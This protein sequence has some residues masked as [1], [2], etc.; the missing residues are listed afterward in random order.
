M[1]AAPIRLQR[2]WLIAA[3]VALMVLLT[4]LAGLAPNTDVGRRWLEQSLEGADLGALGRLHIEGLDGDVWSAPSVRRVTLSDRGGVWMEARSLRFRWR[5][6]SLLD[7]RAQIDVAHIDV[8]RIDHRPQTAPPSTGGGQLPVS[9]HVDRLTARVEMAPKFSGQPGD[10]DLH[11]HLALDRDGTANIGIVAN[12]R[13]ALSDH[14]DA[15]FA[16]SRRK[17]FQ[18]SADL[19]EPAGGALAGMIGLP[20]NQPFRLTARAAGD[21]KA[22]KVSV[23]SRLADS[24]PLILNGAWSEAGGQASGDV[25][26]AASSLLSGYID[27]IGPHLHLVV[28]GRSTGAGFADFQFVGGGANA[29]LVASGAANIGKFAT[30]PKG[31]AMTLKVANAN[32]LSSFP[33][34]GQATFAGIVTGASQR[35]TANGVADL[36]QVSDGGYRLARVSGPLHVTYADREFQIVAEPAGVGGSGEGLLAAL[37]GARPHGR[38]EVNRLADG[39]LLIRSATVEGV[40]LSMTGTGKRG[41]LG[42][43]SFVGTG[44]FTN[45]KLAHAGAHGSVSFGWTA[46]QAGRA[47]W[48]LSVDARGQNFTSG[49][50]E[51]DRLLGR[52][53]RL[54]AKAVWEKSTLS[55][56]ASEIAGANGHLDSVGNIGGDGALALKLAWVA[57]GP[58]A[59]G[60]LEIVGKADG[61]GALTGSIGAPRVDLIADFA[62]VSAPG[63]PLSKAHLILTFQHAADGDDGHFA[64]TAD[65]AYGAASAVSGFRLVSDG[66]DFTDLAVKGGGIEARGALALHAGAP[67]SADLGLTIGPGAMISRGQVHGRLKIAGAAGHA[68]ASASLQG[69]EL[70]LRDNGLAIKAIEITADG[71]VDRLPYRL[72]ANGPSA[73]GPWRIAGNGALAQQNDQTIASFTGGAHWR[74][75]DLRTLAPAEALFTNAGYSL[76]ASLAAGAGRADVAFSNLGP[77]AHLKATVANLDMALL[78]EDYVGKFSGELNLAG[79]GAQLQ[80]DLDARLSGAGGR[81]LRGAPPVNG[82]IKAALAG[83]SMHVRFDLGN[84]SGLAASGEWTLPMDAAAQPFHLAVDGRRH[85]TGRLMV[86]GEVKPIWD[87]A[88][89]GSNSLSGQMNAELNFSGTLADP[90]ASGHLAL[91][92]GRFQDEVSGLDLR[93]VSLHANLI[94][95]V[96]QVSQFSATDPLRGTVTGAGQASLIRDG[97]SNFRA[98][99]SNFRLV[100]TNLARITASGPLS[101]SRAANGK[102][103]ISGALVVDQADISPNP[104]LANGVTPMDVVEI[105]RPDALDD[106]PVTAATNTPREAPV[107]LDVA[108]RAPG[109]VFLKGRGLNLEFALDAHVTG[110][111]VQPDLTGEA[112]VVRG[113]YNFAGQRFLVDDRGIVRL[114]STPQTIRLDLT[115]TREDPALTAIIRITGTA[116]KPVILLS[117]NPSLPQD[118]ILSQVL[119][120][121]SASQLSGLEAAQL[122]SAV[123]GLSGGGGFDLIGGLRSLAHLDRLAIADSNVTG[124]TI[125]GGKYIGDRLYVQLTGGGR[126]GES[127]QIEWRVKRRLS[128]IGKLGSAGDSQIAVRWRKNY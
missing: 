36:D 54:Q 44:S 85:L 78:D 18:L 4:L 17:A 109:R 123:A 111:A 10:Y 100:D 40:G 92:K 61:G 82:E 57:A 62:G 68:Q 20:A 38:A 128:L 46:S 79:R 43:L 87:L 119:F 90:R 103:L 21:L 19:T 77:E 107:G 32:R 94:D 25:D 15:Q 24:R 112:R 105:N 39:R 42:D 49:W 51:A 60:P 7:R 9:V 12:S 11:G 124:T 63:L 70:V 76:A 91:D 23:D 3:P 67:S 122:A 115:A 120:G 65:S 83:G 29:Q 55:V 69:R 97:A 121:T 116:A 22:G 50:A 14:L 88:L 98:Q 106:Q 1:A 108:I 48:G 58:F 127:A 41:L 6:L 110:T 73:A 81:D 31:L 101:V 26:L 95:T 5:P 71:P 35:W 66:V 113:D 117:S 74:H 84:T 86:N 16:I 99:L 89:A 93:N 102:V 52:M 118:E 56:T 126:E 125:S 104:P 34:M 47:P 28:R 33:K 59:L 45:L 8:V 75:A 96:V 27:L 13:Q 53:P 114:G 80:G 30:G 72:A 64:L 37:L 2:R